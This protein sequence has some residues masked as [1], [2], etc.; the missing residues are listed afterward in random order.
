MDAQ[1]R[2]PVEPIHTDAELASAESD[3]LAL[4]AQLRAMSGAAPAGWPYPPA[5]VGVGTTIHRPSN[6]NVPQP[7]N[8]TVDE[9]LSPATTIAARLRPSL[10][11]LWINLPAT[12]RPERTN[13]HRAY[14][15]AILCDLMAAM[16][17][18]VPNPDLRLLAPDAMTQI[19][20]HMTRMGLTREEITEAANTALDLHWEELEQEALA[21]INKITAR[22]APEWAWSMVDALL[23]QEAED[24]SN[25]SAAQSACAANNGIIA[26]RVATARPDLGELLV[27]DL[28]DEPGYIESEVTL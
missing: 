9:P 5:P 4:Q 14:E 25:D 26:M 27:D 19:M 12:A 1:A 20:H 28:V 8:V 16:T 6:T 21:A 22:R 11:G 7:V 2:E 17:Y 24:M 13:D 15:G 10:D 23:H 3:R 18:S